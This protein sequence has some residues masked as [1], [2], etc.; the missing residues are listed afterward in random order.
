MLSKSIAFFSFEIGLDN[1]I[2]SYA[3]GLGILA[4]D[5]LKS[6]TD[7]NLDMLGVSLLYSKGIFQQALDEDGN[8]TEFYADWEPAK[9]MRLLEETFYIKIEN[10]RVRVQIW[11]YFL[12]GSSGHKNPIYFLDT[13]CRENEEIDQLICKEVYPNDQTVWLKQ[14]ILLGLGSIQALKLLKY[15]VLDNYHLNE[16]HDMFVL[17][18]LRKELGSWEEVKKRAI[19][20]VHTPLPG[21]HKSLEMSKIEQILDSRYF[22]L[23]PEQDRQSGELN[24]TEFAIRFSKYANGVALKHEEVTQQ[25]YP[26][27]QIDSVTNGVHPGTWLAK[28]LQKILDQH[29]PRWRQDPIKLRL[30]DRLPEAD[31][32]AAHSLAKQDLIDFVKDQT[33]ENLSLKVFTIGFARRA[34]SYKRANFIFSDF[35]RLEEIAE[36]NGGLQIIFAGK[37]SPADGPGKEIIR[38]LFAYKSRASENL[39]IVY[40]PNYNMEISSK[41]VAGCDLWLNNPMVPLEASGTS[42]MKANL[43]GVPNFSALDGWWIEGWVEGV[44]GWSIGKEINDEENKIKEIEDVYGKLENKILP[45]YRDHTEWVK[46]MKKCIAVNGSYFHTHRVLMEYLSEAYIR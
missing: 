14:Q 34:V 15:P 40:L 17:L 25:T 27:Y 32:Y 11:E 22:Q 5:M 29:L 21:A 18:G 30:A 44:T 26:E 3:G 46:I 31:L 28:P 9:F 19:T 6:A 39:K 16:S 35:A 20:T 1:R 7:M 13:N 38:S 42:G 23:F 24:Q 4:G 12:E 8:Q 2:P 37:A 10:R 45:T 36:K 41:M 33:G 43:N